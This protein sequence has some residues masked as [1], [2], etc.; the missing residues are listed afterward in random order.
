[1]WGGG[2]PDRPVRVRGFGVTM[3]LLCAAAAATALL[4]VASPVLAGDTVTIDYAAWEACIAEHADDDDLGASACWNAGIPEHLHEEPPDPED[5]SEDFHPI[6][7]ARTAPAPMAHQGGHS[8]FSQFPY[9]SAYYDGPFGYET[10]ADGNY[11]DVSV[12]GSQPM[13]Y[14]PD[15]EVISNGPGVAPSVSDGPRAPVSVDS[16]NIA[17]PDNGLT[18]EQNA[19]VAM[20]RCMKGY[21]ERFES[22]GGEPQ[23]DLDWAWAARVQAYM[24]NDPN[25]RAGSR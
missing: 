8:G 15:R 3:R 17:D 20:L 10:D 16:I 18:P 21:M 14:D 5:D 9:G 19:E 12:G 23:S 13:M 24:D 7:Y 4:A 11:V 1:M 6:V 2:A 25:C 22:T